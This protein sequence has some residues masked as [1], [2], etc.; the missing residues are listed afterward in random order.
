MQLKLLPHLKVALTLFTCR[1][2]EAI[3]DNEMVFIQTCSDGEV[4]TDFLRCCQVERGNAPGIKAIKKAVS[5]LAP[6]EEFN[7]KL[8]ALGSDG[9]SVMLGRKNG[10]IALLQQNKPDVIFD[11]I[12]RY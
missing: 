6:W 8:V 11:C 9:A 2:F 1:S 10:V 12:S 7:E 5:F 4:Y 3:I